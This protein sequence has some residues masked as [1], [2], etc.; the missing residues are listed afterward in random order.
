MTG[1]ELIT[2]ERA[3]QIN[4]HGYSIHRDMDQNPYGELKDAALALLDEIGYYFPDNWD[5]SITEKMAAKDYK[6][7]LVI[8]GA[9]LAAELDRILALESQSKHQP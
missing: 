6:T 5:H 1:I 8:A 2:A 4:K 3:E 9:L 7:R